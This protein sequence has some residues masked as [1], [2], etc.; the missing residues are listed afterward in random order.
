MENAFAGTSLFRFIS[1]VFFNKTNVNLAG[2]VIS[3]LLRLSSV[4]TMQM[5]LNWG[6]RLMY[7]LLIPQRTTCIFINVNGVASHYVIG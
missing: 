5:L 1:R 7:F 6:E 2:K 4:Y 3:D